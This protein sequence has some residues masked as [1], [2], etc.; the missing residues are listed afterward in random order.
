MSL[1]ASLRF[2][3]LF[4]LAAVP[5]SCGSS[6]SSGGSSGTGGSGDDITVNFAGPQAATPISSTK[7]VVSWLDASNSAGDPASSMTYEVYRSSALTLADETLIGTTSPG[8]TSY[9]DSG[10]A[11]NGNQTYFYR[12]VALDVFENESVNN[13]VVSA[14]PPASVVSGT[15]NFTD[16]VLPLFSL[17]GDTVLP[18]PEANITCLDCHIPSGG[19][20]ATEA[21]YSTYAGLVIGVGTSSSPDSWLSP[22]QGTATAS[23]FLNRFWNYPGTPV[24]AAT[25][26]GASGA[27]YDTKT[28][29][30]QAF[31][32]AL[33]DWANE[34]GLESEDTERPV[35]DFTDIGNTTYEA[36]YDLGNDE[37]T[38]TTFHASDPESQAFWPN[39]QLM[40]RI[41]GGL[42]SNTIDWD[43]PLVETDRNIYAMD[44]DISITFSYSAATG[45]FVVRA[46]DF[47]GNESLNESELEVSR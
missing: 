25:A 8:V 42:T 11:G 12:V 14:H 22:G 7:V 37:V 4:A 5:L 46:V 39:D 27:G 40:Y 10:L 47:E 35:M 20:L 38:I 2:T 30:L 21:D 32:D 41:Y 23:E 9:V 1:S 44:S 31:A 17:E 45:V 29:D 13:T 28:A 33:K 34:G 36:S 18:G 43:T 16:D 24:D 26:H 19:V 3:L 15:L 6:S